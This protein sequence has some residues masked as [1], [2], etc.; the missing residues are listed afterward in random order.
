MLLLLVLKIITI[1]FSIMFIKSSF[2]SI[3]HKKKI[4]HDYKYMYKVKRNLHFDLKR[5]IK[6]YT[7]IVLKFFSHLYRRLL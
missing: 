6:I 2:N 3:F 4:L 1:L 7:Y 5:K